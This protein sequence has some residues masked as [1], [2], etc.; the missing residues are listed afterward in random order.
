M[1]MK[2]GTY[3][4]GEVLVQKRVYLEMFQVF[5][6]NHFN[7]HNRA[8]QLWIVLYSRKIFNAVKIITLS[9]CKY[10]FHQITHRILVIFYLP[11]N[12]DK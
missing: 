10:I 7:L 4:L 1:V 5:S 12:I 2:K 9:Q 3:Q 6:L 11:Q 8:N